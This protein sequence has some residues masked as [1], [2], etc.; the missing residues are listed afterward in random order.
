MP[1]RTFGHGIH[2]LAT[3]L[4]MGFWIP[5]WI[6]RYMKWKGEVDARERERRG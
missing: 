2:A 1:S 4:T 6:W 5:I 3:V